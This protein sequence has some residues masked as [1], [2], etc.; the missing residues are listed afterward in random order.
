MPAARRALP[1]EHDEDS[2][3]DKESDD[4][5]AVSLSEHRKCLQR[6]IRHRRIRQDY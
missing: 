2:M 6:P 1:G 3:P 5:P 4:Q